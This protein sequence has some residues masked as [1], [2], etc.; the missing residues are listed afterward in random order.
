MSLSYRFKAVREENRLVIE[1]DSL[2][3]AIDEADSRTKTFLEEEG[4]SGHAFHIRLLAREGLSNAIR[5]GHADDPEKTVRYVVAVEPGRVVLTFTD[6]GPGFDWRKRKEKHPNP[7][8]EGGRGLWIM[9]TYASEYRY[10]EKGNE[11]TLVKSI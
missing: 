11:L 6:E 9:Q 2:L 7:E 10:N 4:L 8:D 3:E 1:M 5:H